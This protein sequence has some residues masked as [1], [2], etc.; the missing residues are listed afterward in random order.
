MSVWV[1]FLDIGLVGVWIWGLRVWSL[2][3]RVEGLTL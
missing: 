2:G 1:F 3:F